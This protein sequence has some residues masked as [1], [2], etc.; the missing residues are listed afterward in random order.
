MRANVTLNMC[1]ERKSKMNW[2]IKAVFIMV[3]FLQLVSTAYGTAEFKFDEKMFENHGSVML[4]INADTGDIIAANSAAIDFYGYSR[5]K[6]LDMKITQINSLSAEETKSEMKMA[7]EEHR[8][9]FKFEHKLK[10]GEI[11]YVEVYS[12]PFSNQE[13]QNLLFSII[14]D[15][16]ENIMLERESNIKKYT[17]IGILL[18]AFINTLIFSLYILKT[19]TKLRQINGDLKN[20]FEN[21][22][23]GFALH[24]IIVDSKGEAIDYVF[25]EMNQAFQAMTGLKAEAILGKSVLEVLPQTEKYW[26]ENYGRVALKGDGNNLTHYS[27]ELGKYFEVNAYSPK[28]GQFVT[29]ISDVTE[30]VE[31]AAAL[32]LERELFKTTLHSLGDGVI[33]TDKNGR[34]EIMNAVA[35]ELTGWQLDE[36]KGRPFE[37]VFDIVDDMTELPIE[38][39][40]S[41]VMRTGNRTDIGASAVLIDKR[42]LKTPVEDS[43]APIKDE[44]GNIKGVVLVFRDFTEKKEKNDQILYLSYH[45]QLT[46]LYNRRF[47]E[48]ELERLDTFRNLPF[49]IAMVDV[50]GLKLTNDA[51]GHLMGDELL[52]R[53]ANVLRKEFRAD[54]IIARTGGDEFVILLPKT[55][56][57]K[58]ELIVRR[59]YE[60]IR[61]EEFGPIIMSASIGFE[62]KWQDENIKD[63][64]KKAE[65]HMYKRK[66]TESQIMR[67]QTLHSIIESLNK[68]IPYEKQHAD[69]VTYYALKLGKKMNLSEETLRD[70]E[71]AARMHDIG[72]ISVSEYILNKDNYFTKAEYEVVKRHSESGYQI[73]KTIDE[74]SMIAEYVLFHHERWDG[75]GY[76]KRLS[77]EDI[78]LISRII[79][80]SE[81]FEAMTESRS[82]RQKLSSEEAL[83]EIRNNAGSQF[84]PTIVEVF[85][86]LKD[87]LFLPKFK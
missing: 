3:L 53:I 80:I 38:S 69:N 18:F 84:D 27:N 74:Y 7:I 67:H 30:R 4:I 5:E 56:Y 26:I 21:M 79:A 9:Y 78:P 70:L 40:V 72:K 36:A 60:S 6:L 66:I 68:K 25:L 29:I 12:Y 10:N 33:S 52:R 11:R 55:D 2:P 23:E 59:V 49:S 48:E 42:G 22:N 20:L 54:D 8:N 64:F 24:E 75:T 13:N 81:A 86:E 37:E 87:E 15:V 77:G 51:F 31:S 35:E 34:I 1:N 83:E 47:F 45:D 73:L 28:I 58:A 82:Y 41:V 17:I 61:A 19:K 57:Q 46:G 39:P 44:V 63:I 62:T 76:P 14:H 16:T 32:N 50:N 43:A 85:L 71:L 65:E